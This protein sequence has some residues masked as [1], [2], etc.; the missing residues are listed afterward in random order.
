MGRHDSP[1]G[2]VVPADERR[3]RRVLRRVLHVCHAAPVL[4][5]SA[6]HRLLHGRHGGVGRMRQVPARRAVRAGVH[7]MR[8][9]SLWCRAEVAWV[10]M[11]RRSV[12][13]LRRLR[14]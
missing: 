13:G 14:H 8:G 4:L 1:A 7:M 10:G 5:V 6:W 3:M 11:M 2:R 12:P 9:I